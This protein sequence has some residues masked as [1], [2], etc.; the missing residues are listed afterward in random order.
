MSEHGAFSACWAATYQMG[1]F[2]HFRA[3]LRQ[4]A[5]ESRAVCMLSDRLTLG[6]GPPQRLFA[7]HSTQACSS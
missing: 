2:A 7:A 5:V 4:Q 6:A 1:L 3:V